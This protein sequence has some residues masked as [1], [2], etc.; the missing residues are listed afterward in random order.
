MRIARIVAD[1]ICYRIKQDIS[2]KGRAD[3]VFLYSGPR[4]LCAFFVAVNLPIGVFHR[5]RS[6][7]QN[8]L[9]VSQANVLIVLCDESLQERC[10]WATKYERFYERVA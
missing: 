7:S 4:A 2:A 10:G 9:Q 6:S 8:P 1:F 5:N 3:K